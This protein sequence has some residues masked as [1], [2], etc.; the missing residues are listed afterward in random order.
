MKGQWKKKWKQNGVKG[1]C[2]FRFMDYWWRKAAWCLVETLRSYW[3]NSMHSLSGFVLFQLFGLPVTPSI[4]CLITMYLSEWCFCCFFFPPTRN[5]SFSCEAA[6]VAVEMFV[7]PEKIHVR[8]CK[9]AARCS[10]GWRESGH[11]KIK[12]TVYSPCW[13]PAL[14]IWAVIFQSLS[15]S[16]SVHYLSLG[17]FCKNCSCIS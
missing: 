8:K 13:L 9:L 7:T 16:C 17:N 2:N 14:N 3:Q 10:S 4:I 1:I 5:R 12:D 15:V 6:V 11:F